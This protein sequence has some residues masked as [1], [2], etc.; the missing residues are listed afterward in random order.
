LAN[1]QAYIEDSQVVF[2]HPVVPPEREG[3]GLE[4]NVFEIADEDERVLRVQR[5]PQL[6]EVEAKH[7]RW[8][9]TQ[10]ITVITYALQSVCI[11]PV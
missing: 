7:T 2:W 11:L 4:E 5:S 8:Y 6:E 3:I 10:H 9:P 1:E